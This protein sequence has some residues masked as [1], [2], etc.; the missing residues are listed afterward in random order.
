MQQTLVPSIKVEIISWVGE[1]I[2]NK[3]SVQSLSQNVWYHVIRVRHLEPFMGH[4]TAVSVA[5]PTTRKG[6]PVTWP[7]RVIWDHLGVTWQVCCLLHK[8]L[9]LT[10][11]FAASCKLPKI[12]GYTT[13]KYPM[14]LKSDSIVTFGCAPGYDMVGNTPPLLVMCSDVVTVPICKSKCPHIVLRSSWHEK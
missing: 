8:L 1:K 11:L 4:M 7:V 13:V 3:S 6:F 5:A 9:V 14:P 2:L 12:P 10:H